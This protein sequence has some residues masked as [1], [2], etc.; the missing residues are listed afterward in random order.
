[1]RPLVRTFTVQ[2]TAKFAAS[3]YSQLHFRQL[4]K[5]PRQSTPACIRCQFPPTA[6][7]YSTED[8]K[9]SPNNLFSDKPAE[10]PLDF[11]PN[12]SQNAPEA[13]EKP[14]A[15]FKP[16][17][18]SKPTPAD[19]IADFRKNLP[20]ELERR[21]SEYSKRFSKAMDDLQTAV[22]TA[23]QKLNDLTGYTEIEALKRAISAQEA[24]VRAS[25]AAVRQAKEDYTAAINRRSASQ[26]EVNEL[27][28]RKHAWSSTDLERFTQLYRSDHTNE[29]EELA[30]QERLSKSESAADEAQAQLARSILA[31]YH[32]E[33]IWS[34][35]IRRASTWG[36]W[37]LMGFNVLLFVVVQL[38]LEPWKRKR[39]V[40][41]FEEKVR[42]VIKEENE[43]LILETAAA[44]A[45]EAVVAE[46]EAA[47]KEEVVAE[48]EPVQVIEEPVVE[49]PVIVTRPEPVGW[50]EKALDQAQYA[51]HQ[52]KRAAEELV[53][54]K[55]VVTTQREITI[56]AA[57]SM[58]AG[59][60]ITGL[61]FIIAN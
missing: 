29:Q 38:G 37:G 22:F 50:E 54:E 32:E 58:V 46:E 25:R 2:P 20:S 33:Q 48:V 59:A 36:T 15:D 49:T 35:K 17:A 39:L 1:M 61:G 8:K 47:A 34:D 60:A 42:E 51:Y 4:S 6:R 41:G 12:A 53:S 27:L 10:K 57:T 40:G 7:F 30:A 28:Q 55:E 43:K 24:H 44:A 26:R 21:R 14:A 13:A 16:T 52:I 56:T 23:G 3:T 9:P 18:D 31:R 19:Q 11:E 5:L 45:V